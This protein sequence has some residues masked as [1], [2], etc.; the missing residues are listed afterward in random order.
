MAGGLALTWF[1]AQVATSTRRV[2]PVHLEGGAAVARVREPVNDVARQ[3]GLLQGE[4]SARSVL[5]AYWGGK[6]PEIEKALLADGADLDRHFVLTPWDEVE[7][8]LREEMV[9]LPEDAKE[10]FVETK[11]RWP[12]ENVF[13]WLGEEYRRPETFTES[14]MYELES[15]VDPINE[16]LSGLAWYYLEQTSAAMRLLWSQGRIVRAPFSTTG[17]PSPY[18]KDNAFLSRSMASG[19]GWSLTVSLDRDEFADVLAIQKE[20]RTLRKKRDAVIRQ[21]FQDFE[22]R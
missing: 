18:P 11:V 21:F 12:A 15:L 10:D 1:A 20:M 13:Q 14:H 8:A 2:P 5:E 3:A 16:E 22:S 6:W 7:E 17:A 9:E 4:A 19:S